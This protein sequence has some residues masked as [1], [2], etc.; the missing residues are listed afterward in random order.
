MSNSALLASTLPPPPPLRSTSSLPFALTVLCHPDWQRLGAVALLPRFSEGVPLELSRVSPGFVDPLS[1]REPLP[2]TDPFLSRSP[3]MLTWREGKVHVAPRSEIELSVQG[4]RLTAPA[5]FELPPTG[6]V[7]MLGR[8]VVLLLHRHPGRWREH[9]HGLVGQSHSLLRAIDEL[10]Q[11]APTQLPVL[12]RGETGTGKE[13][14]A[15]AIHELSP[16]AGKPF[17]A[18]NLAAIA[19]SVAA[20]EL[21]GH[22]AG[23]FTG[24]S[25]GH[26][27]YFAE[28]AGGTLFLDEIGEL[29]TDTQAML[30]RVL[31]GGDVQ[32]VGSSRPVRVDVRVVAATDSD[33]EAALADGRFRPALFHRLA[34]FQLGLPSL[35]ERLDDLGRLMRHFSDFQGELLTAPAVERLALAPWTGNVRELRNVLGQLTLARKASPG[36]LEDHPALAKLAQVNAAAPSPANEAGPVD[37]QRILETL[38]AQ[39]WRLSA[40]ARAL[41]ISRTTLYARIDGNPLLRKASDVPVEELKAAWAECGG[42]AEEVARRLE[43]SA[44]A[45]VLRVRA[46]GL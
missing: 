20:S 33:L 3:V 37:D 21:F 39:Q 14:I 6:L 11:V 28:A 24:A 17:I 2:L 35:R 19:P 23:A 40:T 42:D 29:G 36:P 12:I 34:A 9:T 22:A 13:L 4:A 45:I 43:V 26:P 41:G 25:R 44:R 10:H 18:V 38:R 5:E 15:R 46:L 32:P 8:R 1:P 16:R 30:L 27:G 31:E 7:L